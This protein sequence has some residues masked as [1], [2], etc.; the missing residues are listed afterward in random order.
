[1][2]LKARKTAS[3]WTDW[4]RTDV[5]VLYPTGHSLALASVWRLGPWDTAALF[6]EAAWPWAVASLLNVFILSEVGFNFSGPHPAAWGKA[7]HQNIMPSLPEAICY[8]GFQKQ[9]KN[10]SHILYRMWDNFFFALQYVPNLIPVTIH[11]VQSKRKIFSL[12]FFFPSFHMADWFISYYKLFSSLKCDLWCFKW[13]Y[14]CLNG[15]VWHGV[16]ISKHRL[17]SQ[18]ELG[19]KCRSDYLLAIK[20]WL[21]HLHSLHHYVLNSKMRTNLKSHISSL[22]KTLLWAFTSLNYLFATYLFENKYSLP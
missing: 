7:C 20:H 14:H 2:L 22:K 8:P 15:A 17:W 16:S 1:M 21:N 13:I 4:R 5:N 11:I 3:T 12:F 10:A 18:R 19:L 6:K 9:K